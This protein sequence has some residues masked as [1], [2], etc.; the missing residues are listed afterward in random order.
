[1]RHITIIAAVI[2]LA[3]EG[4]L[5]AQ[6]SGGETRGLFGRR[7]L[8]GTLQPR[9]RTLVNGLVTAP[10]GDFL[11]RG[12][13]RGLTFN[14]SIWQSADTQRQQSE[15]RQQWR[16]SQEVPI[17]TPQQLGPPPAPGLA[18]HAEAPQVPAPP[19]ATPPAEERW[20]RSPPAGRAQAGMSPAPASTGAVRAETGA[21]PGGAAPV[22][23]PQVSLEVGFSPPAGSRGPGPF[24]TALL[25]R[26]P[27]IARVSPISV[28]MESDTAVL[29]G[30]VRSP[31][32]RQLAEDIVRLEPGVWEVR[33]E[34]VV[35]G[36]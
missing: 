17:G 8:G 9:P 27:Q 13:A 2:T 4:N 20:F 26:T 11:G 22:R 24:L 1:M 36:Q 32:D 21:S 3:I 12:R 10:S 6:S 29:R 33:N 18:Q 31:R 19:A 7:S 14:P 5:W 30:Q 28:T 34:L 35:T 16:E 25:T 23:L 15:W